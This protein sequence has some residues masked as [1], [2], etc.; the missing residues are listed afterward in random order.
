MKFISIILMSIFCLEIHAAECNNGRC[1]VR[2]APKQ[3]I[4]VVQ[5]VSKGTIRVVTPPYKGR[6]MNGKCIK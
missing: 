3:S 1:F 6:C 5:N 4:Q 2:S